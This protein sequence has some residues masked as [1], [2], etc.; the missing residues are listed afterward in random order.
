[1]DSVFKHSS[2]YQAIV[3]QA[4]VEEA[5]RLLLLLGRRKF[6]PTNTVVRA[7]L[8]QINTLRPLEALLL[9]L[10]SVHN[11]QELLAPTLGGGQRRSGERASTSPGNHPRGN[12]SVN[13]RSPR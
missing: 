8:Q 2:T 6:G 11:W 12:R 7:V 13:A 9:R 4:Q 10:L 3:R 1:M 5:S